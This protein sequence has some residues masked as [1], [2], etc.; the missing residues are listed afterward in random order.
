M[1]KTDQTPDALLTEEIIA[2]LRKDRLFS[3]KQLEALPAK[4]AS[5]K[6]RAEDWQVMIELAL[7]AEAMKSA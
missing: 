4:L 5:G 7:D 3:D 6:M 2:A 1:T